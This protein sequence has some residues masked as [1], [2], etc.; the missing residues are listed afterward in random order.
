MP[1]T[2]TIYRCLIIC[3]SDV[4]QEKLTVVEAL[5]RWNASLGDYAKVQIQPVH[6][7]YAT[8]EMSDPAQTVINRQMVD[9]CDFGIAVFWSRLGTKTQDHESG[10]VEEISAL[11][12]RGCW[13]GVYFSDAPVPQQPRS[14]Y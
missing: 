12:K 2:A 7:G 10:S 14:R 13:V 9:S 5:N 11:R 1:Q 4:E 3:P 6:W 8:P